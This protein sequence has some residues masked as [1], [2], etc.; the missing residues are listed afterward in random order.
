MLAAKGMA[1]LMV[2]S[3]TTELITICDRVI[4]IHEGTLS[5]ELVKDDSSPADLNEENIMQCATGN[6]K[7]FYVKAGEGA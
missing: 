3:E 7:L 1:I 5:G 2:T 4:V 6:K